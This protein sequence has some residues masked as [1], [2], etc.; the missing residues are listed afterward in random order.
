MEVFI[1]AEVPIRMYIVLSFMA[2]IMLWV[3]MKNILPQR[4]VTK[5][6][7]STFQITLRVLFAHS[8]TISSIPVEYK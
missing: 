7:H 6:V 4:I 3:I 8:Y 1:Q 5:S 2:G